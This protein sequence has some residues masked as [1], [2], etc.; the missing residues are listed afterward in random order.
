[1]GLI[2]THCHIH[3][4]VEQG[5]SQDGVHQKWRKA[6]VDDAEAV[7]AAAHEA[8][9]DGLVCVG[10]DVDDSALAVGFVQDRD[11]AWAT[12]GIHPHEAQRYVDDDA[13]LQRFAAL[14]DRPRVVGVGECGLDYYYGHSPEADQEK[15]LRFQIELALAKDLPLSFHVRDAFDDFWPIFDSY[16]ASTPVRGVLHSFTADRA[17]LDQA[18]ERGLYVALNGIM[19]FTKDKAQL[20]AAKAVP[21][22]RLL[23]ETDAPYL[24]PAPKRGTICEPKH[25]RVTLEFLAALREEDAPTLVAATTTNARLLFGLPG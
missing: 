2:D 16:H 18:M 12:V 19:T 10:T 9:V 14:S 17:V 5:N 15:I 4:I 3:E 22:D 6:G 23:L 8:G 20:A 11:D 13:E 7:A 25:V 24:T 1:M 21:L